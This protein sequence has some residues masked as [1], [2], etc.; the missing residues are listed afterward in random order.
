MYIFLIRIQ[1]KDSLD[2]NKFYDYDK[3]KLGVSQR[4]IRYS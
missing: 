2:E 3:R 1:E 4:F